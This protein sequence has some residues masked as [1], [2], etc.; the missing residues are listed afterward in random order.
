[1]E[2]AVETKKVGAGIITMS[3][4]YLVGQF[5]VILGSLVNIFGSDFINS[6]YESMGM[7]NVLETVNMTDIYITLAI[8]VIITI[9]V[10]LLLAKKPMGA[11]IF[12]GIEI[13]SRIYGVISSG[14]GLFTFIMLIF[15]VLMILFIYKKKDIYFAKE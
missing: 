8:S 1:M 2:N 5:F 15:P 10:A 4:L 13:L 3:V 7:P 6:Y 14:V 9:S 11:Y 12:I